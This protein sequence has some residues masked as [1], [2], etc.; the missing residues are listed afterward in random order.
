PVGRARDLEPGLRAELLL[1]R[2]AEA[3]VCIARP[4]DI[5]HPVPPHTIELVARDQVLELGEGCLA[6]HAQR[7]DEPVSAL[8][9]LEA[10]LMDALCPVVVDLA[11]GRHRLPRPTVPD[12]LEVG[13]GPDPSLSERGH[14]LADE[15]AATEVREVMAYG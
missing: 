4:E 3:R 2:I 6:G 1:A 11:P 15:V 13:D 14:E 12:R 7:A 9:E 10:R 5:A 8:A